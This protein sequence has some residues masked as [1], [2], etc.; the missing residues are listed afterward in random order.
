MPVLTHGA[1]VVTFIK[2]AAGV[3]NG[4]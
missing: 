2:R 4:Q 3:Y 1:E